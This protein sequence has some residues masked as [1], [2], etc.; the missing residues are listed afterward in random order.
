MNLPATLEEETDRILS[1]FTRL[2]GRRLKRDYPD[3]L[4]ALA[5]SS[6][7]IFTAHCLPAWLENPTDQMP[8]RDLSVLSG[9]K[10]KPGDVGPTRFFSHVTESEPRV[11][12]QL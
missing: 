8:P 11:R 4:T 10:I 5:K 7:Q 3:T 6:D 12:G 1:R 2:V 9:S